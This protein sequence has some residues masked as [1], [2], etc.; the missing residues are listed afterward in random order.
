[1]KTLVLLCDNY[2]LTPYEP[3]LESEIKAIGSMNTSMLHQFLHISKKSGI[4]GV[5]LATTGLND[6]RTKN[7]LNRLRVK[8]GINAIALDRDDLIDVRNSSDLLF[9]STPDS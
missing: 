1:M 3:F 4:R 6:E 5:I 8:E 9:I 2:P 7:L